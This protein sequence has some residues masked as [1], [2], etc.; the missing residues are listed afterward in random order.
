MYRLMIG[1]EH[2][3]VIGSWTYVGGPECDTDH[4]L[5]VAMVREELTASKSAAQKF[6]KGGFNPK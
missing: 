1:R 3:K 2:K 5:V 6:G 4:C